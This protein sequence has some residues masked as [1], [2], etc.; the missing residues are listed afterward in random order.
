MSIVILDSVK[1]KITATASF[2]NGSSWAAEFDFDAYKT[3][4]PTQYL[5]PDDW[6]SCANNEWYTLPSGNM[7][8]HV[9]GIKLNDMRK[10]T[11]KKAGGFLAEITTR[12][13]AQTLLYI[14]QKLSTAGKKS[15]NNFA[16][17]A[18]AHNGRWIWENSGNEVDLG[19]GHILKPASEDVD[20]YPYPGKYLYMKL[21]N[22]PSST[23]GFMKTLP[24]FDLFAVPGYDAEEEFLCMKK[25]CA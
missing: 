13:D 10:D 7:V 23:T 16:L 12:D 3:D 2:S 20:L 4:I 9:A 24:Y 14:M 19:V 8:C 6:L 17:G 1:T 18:K 22:P 5:N 15:T 25:G 11:C 21:Q